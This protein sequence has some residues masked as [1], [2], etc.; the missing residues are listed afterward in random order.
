[1]FGHVGRRTA[2]LAA[3][4]EALQQAQCDQDDRRR[5]A[6]GRRVGQQAD[7]EGR[8]AHDQNSDEE[9]VFAADDVADAPEH[10]GAERA[11]QEAGG[12]GQQREDVAGCRRI[13]R[14]ELRADDAGERSVEVE[15]VPFEHGAERGSE[16][17]ETFVLRHS[18]G[19]AGC[20][21]HSGHFNTP[22]N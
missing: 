6:D 16:N 13:G 12:E 21:S 15:I 4:R 22:Q 17:D 18:C 3:E 20:G 8:Q 9:G 7:D 2:I 14:K 19:L 11:Y 10:D 1:M 5:D